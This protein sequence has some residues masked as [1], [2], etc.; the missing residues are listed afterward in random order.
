MLK[1]LA[2][3]DY[4]EISLSSLFILPVNWQLL[5]SLG[6]RLLLLRICN[7]GTDSVPSRQVQP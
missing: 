4:M 3:F 6:G 1:S 2:L 5:L 7:Y